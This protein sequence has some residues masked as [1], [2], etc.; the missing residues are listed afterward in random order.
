MNFRLL[1]LSGLSLF[2]LSSCEK[3][4]MSKIPQIKLEG[5]GPE[6]RTV[7]KDTTTLAFSLTDGDAD[8]GVNIQAGSYDIFI[9]DKRFDTG[10]AGYYFPAISN[11]VKDPQKGLKGTCYFF[12]TPDLLLPR[13]DS[14]HLKDGDTTH[15]ELY[16]VD[17]AGN[18]SNHITTPDVYMV[19]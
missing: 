18:K 16:I 19:Y 2:A 5:F 7:G 9:N 4:T 6:I 13:L 17:R 3:N 14:V 12:F 1:F 8:L 15:F 10:F 11:E